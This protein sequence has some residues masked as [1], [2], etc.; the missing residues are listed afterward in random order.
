MDVV[1]VI[2]VSHQQIQMLYLTYTKRHMEFS[3][4]KCRVI[5]IYCEYHLK[6]VINDAQ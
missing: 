4:V 1:I 5:V 3:C 6:T 2:I